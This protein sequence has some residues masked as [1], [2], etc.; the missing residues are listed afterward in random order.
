M[1]TNYIEQSHQNF[2]A[3]SYFGPQA[4]APP[5]QIPINY[6]QAMAAYMSTY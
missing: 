4:M 3:P 1:F 6:A 2:R 5:Q